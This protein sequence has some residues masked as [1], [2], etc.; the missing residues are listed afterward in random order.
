[1]DSD[2]TVFLSS[3][4]FGL[5]FDVDSAGGSRGRLIGVHLLTATATRSCGGGG[6]GSQAPP[7]LFAWLPSCEVGSSAPVRLANNSFGDLH[8]NKLIHVNHTTP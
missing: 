3:L 2:A 4:D 1:M 5:M 8:K 7:T 6:H